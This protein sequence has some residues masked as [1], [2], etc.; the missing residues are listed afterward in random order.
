MHLQINRDKLN[1][2]EGRLHGVESK[3]DGFEG[4]LRELSLQHDP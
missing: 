4:K 3:L 1:S 2:I